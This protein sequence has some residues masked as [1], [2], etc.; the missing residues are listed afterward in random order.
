MKSLVLFYRKASS[1]YFDQPRFSLTSL[2]GLNHPWKEIKS[3]ARKSQGPK[4]RFSSQGNREMAS[5]SLLSVSLLSVS[6]LSVSL[7]SVI[8][9]EKVKGLDRKQLVGKC[10]LMIKF[11]VWRKQGQGTQGFRKQVQWVGKQLPS[12]FPFWVGSGSTPFLQGRLLLMVGAGSIPW[13]NLIQQLVSIRGPLPTCFY[14]FRHKGLCSQPALQ[15]VLIPEV[16]I[17]SP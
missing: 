5:V 14:L 3:K 16:I 2:F 12:G 13:F 17:S 6:L 8:S 10:L 9:K 11:R 4:E 15:P 1:G 7:S